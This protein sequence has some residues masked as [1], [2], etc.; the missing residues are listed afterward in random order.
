[1]KKT[2]IM[3]S[4]I[5]G[6]G[7]F[8][9]ACH[10]SKPQAA[11][12]VASTPVASPPQKPAADVGPKTV[13]LLMHG[14]KVLKMKEDGSGDEVMDEV[15]LTNGTKVSKDGKILFSDGSKMT[16]PDGSL[17]QMDG[18]M[19]GNDPL[20]PD[21]EAVKGFQM[22]D[23]KMITVMKDEKTSAMVNY[24][25]LKSGI[26]VETDGTLVMKDG[27]RDQLKEGAVILVNGQRA[28]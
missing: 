25:K 11:P 1:M 10:P 19:Q 5:L 23:G 12:T 6:C 4:W 27:T 7:L 13:G 21:E 28:Q 24:M 9:M 3:A 16:L 18:Q 15:I 14:A 20:M 2:I 17:I 26:V 8:L 22:K